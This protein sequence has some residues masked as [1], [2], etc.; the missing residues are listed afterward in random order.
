MT[1]E[2]LYDVVIVGGGPAGLAAAIYAGRAGLKTVVIERGAFGG[3]IFQTAE[4]ANYP[5]GVVDESG[6]EFSARLTAHADAF[7]A[8]RV[9]GEVTMLN[10]IGPVKDAVVGGNA[11]QG[12]TMILATGSVPVKLGVPGEDAFSGL[13]VSYCAVCDGPF[14]TGKDVFV[15]GGGDSAVEEAMYL[16]KFARKVTIIHRRDEFRAARSIV[17]RAERVDNIEFLLETIVTELGGDGL[18]TRVTVESV[19]T[20]KSRVIKAA[21]GDNFGVFIFAG[22][23]PVSELFGNELDTERGYIVTDER[24]RT[25][26]PGVFAAGDIR[27]KLLRQVVTA[28]S[29]GAVAAIEAEKYMIESGAGCGEK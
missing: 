23:R 17:E 19:E 3:N 22:M 6:A 20:G 29:D 5:G 26:I 11:Y 13:G 12:R 10:L 4:I 1:D 24:M 16:A 18:L 21:E 28:T 27:K 15:V 14:F 8:E 7:G 25:N 2:A 9:S